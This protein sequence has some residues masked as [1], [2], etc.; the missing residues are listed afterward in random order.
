MPVNCQDK[1]REQLVTPTLRPFVVTNCSFF[2]SLSLLF[3]ADRI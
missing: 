2:Q 1:Y 3:Q